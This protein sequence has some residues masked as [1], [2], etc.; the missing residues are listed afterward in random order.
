MKPHMS[1]KSF[2]RENE[3]RHFH[4]LRCSVRWEIFDSLCITGG[5]VSL[6]EHQQYGASHLCYSSDIN[7]PDFLA[8]W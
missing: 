2:S 4:T 7:E 3:A 1:D 8:F 6:G 5:V